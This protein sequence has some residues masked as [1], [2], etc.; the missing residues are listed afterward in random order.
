V[1]TGDTSRIDS[2]IQ[3]LRLAIHMATYTPSKVQS[4]NDNETDASSSNIA[5]Q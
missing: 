3:E 5:P 2:Y 4:N 1:I